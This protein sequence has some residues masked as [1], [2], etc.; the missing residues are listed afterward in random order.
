MLIRHYICLNSS[1]VG[2]GTAQ[3]YAKLIGEVEL[4]PAPDYAIMDEATLR[5]LWNA[6]DLSRP[7][8]IKHPGSAAGT[9][10]PIPAGRN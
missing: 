4:Q 2:V 1:F 8:D 6:P 3:G 9:P 5:K 7:E 10:S